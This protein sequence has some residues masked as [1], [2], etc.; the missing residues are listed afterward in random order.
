MPAWKS[1]ES[2]TEKTANFKF[3]CMEILIVSCLK[4]LKGAAWKP[5][6]EAAAQI[7]AKQVEQVTKNTE[8][9]R[10]HFSHTYYS[11]E[12]KKT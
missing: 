12:Y 2:D 6:K 3:N 1:K 4:D 8:R 10:N 11:T 9:N 7:L 5:S